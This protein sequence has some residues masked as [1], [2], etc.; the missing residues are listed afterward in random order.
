MITR[1]VR[2][3]IF[4][5]AILALA[6]KGDAAKA[7]PVFERPLA[8][9]DAVD[10][11]LANIVQADGQA[12]VRVPVTADDPSKGAAEPLV[13]IVEFSDFQCPHC[14]RGAQAFDELVAAYPQDVRLVFKQFPLPMHPD[15]ELGS[16]ATIA[17]AAQGKFWAM[18]DRLFE[19]RTRM[20]RDDVVAHAKDLGLAE[21]AFA[22]ALDDPR[23]AERVQAD[24]A[25]GLALGV[26]GTPS[27]FVNG[28]PYSGALPGDKLQAIVERERALGRALVDAGSARTEVYARIMRASPDPGEAPAQAEK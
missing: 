1:L 19:N 24:K 5:A 16:R 27:F 22:A 17:A 6:C 15:A 7:D 13:V 9:I 26:R 12:R 23:T 28:V 25:F 11:S 4:A 18:H 14:G 8:A 2:A 10:D 20:K 21:S 3:T